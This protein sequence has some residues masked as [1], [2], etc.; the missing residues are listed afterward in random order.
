MHEKRTTRTNLFSP[1]RPASAQSR[2]TPLQMAQSL[3]GLEQAAL[4]TPRGADRRVH[5]RAGPHSGLRESLVQVLTPIVMIAIWITIWNPIASLL[6]DRWTESRTIEVHRFLQGMDVT[7]VASEDQQREPETPL[8]GVRGEI[9]T[10]EHG[11]IAGDG[12]HRE[13]DLCL[14]D[15]HS[16]I[17][18]STVQPMCR[19]VENSQSAGVARRISASSGRQCL[20]PRFPLTENTQCAPRAARVSTC[21]R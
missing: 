10:E 3:R 1:S 13:P 16:I 6:F 11:V 12:L 4:P 18:S 8:P 17:R 9:E 15:S 19:E 5:D 21:S 7:V 20:T 14:L 2:H